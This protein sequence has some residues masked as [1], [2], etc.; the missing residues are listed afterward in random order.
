MQRILLAAF[1]LTLVACG[2]GYKTAGEADEKKPAATVP[3]NM[4]GF[5]PTY[6]ASFETGDPK[7]SEMILKLWQ[8]WD[9]G[10]LSAS[11]DYFADSLFMYF[12]DG[13]S[14]EGPRD[15][16]LSASQQYRDMF[17]QVKTTLHAIFPVKSTDKNESWVCAWATEVHT[18][19]S[20]KTDSTHLQETWRFKGDK[21]D[22]LF[23]HTRA[24]T[25]PAQPK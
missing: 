4:Y 6:S 2:S 19:K 17:S 16:I 18:D 8:D 5:A 13:S 1:V 25:P 15:S 12:G 14:M 21:V 11:K 20:G 22:L 23:Q 3:A 9:K 7:H 24:G 10:D